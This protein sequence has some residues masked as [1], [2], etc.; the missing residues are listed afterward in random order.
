LNRW[1]DILFTY[2][3]AEDPVCA[4][5]VGGGVM[6][7]HGA[8]FDAKDVFA[9]DVPGEAAAFVKSKLGM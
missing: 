2:C 4:A 3:H 6:A 1:A 9:G 8:Y 5:G 7:F